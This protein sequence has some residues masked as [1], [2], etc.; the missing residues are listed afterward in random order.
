MN[1]GSITLFPTFFTL[2]SHSGLQVVH[3]ELQ[4]FQCAVSVPRLPLVGDQHSDDDQQKQAAPPSDADYGRKCQQ[5]VRV[6]VKSPGG[7]LEPSS[8]DLNTHR[9]LM[10]KY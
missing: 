9:F 4:T 3:L 10:F 2:Q 7:V 1:K 6:D 5:A 8:T